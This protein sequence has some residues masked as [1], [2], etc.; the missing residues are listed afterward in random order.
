MRQ[1]ELPARPT[2]A[3]DRPDGRR[4]RAA[5]NRDSVVTA[6]LEIIME[7]GG[8]PSPGAAEVAL[9]AAVSE[10]TV[11]RHFADLDSLLAAAAARQRPALIS[12]LAPR[13]SQAGLGARITAIVR[14]RSELHE[15]ITPV[16][17]VAVKLAATH[18]VVADE[19]EE[20]HELARAQL[21]EVF[22][23]ELKG[24]A[25]KRR[26][27]LL[28]ELDVV[29]SF[30]AWETLRGAQALSP[31]QARKVVSDLLGAVLTALDGTKR[32]HRAR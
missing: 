26:A 16:R 8:G 29:T 10:R 4:L 32:Q 30:G 27:S 11:F 25:P 19:I 24:L 12:H 13:P 1:P 9:R 5:R 23:P 31:P 2:G 17:R 15:E 7:Q 3:L 21:A 18:R 28:N 6:V 14:L 20:A 22:A